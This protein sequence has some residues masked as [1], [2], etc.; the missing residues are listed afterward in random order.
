MKLLALLG[1]ENSSVATIAACVATDPVFT[2]RVLKRA[3]AADLA[4]YKPTCNILQALVT[5]GIERTRQ[6]TLTIATM[7]YLGKALK[8]EQ[9]RRCWSHT[10]ACALASSQ[11][12]EICG[13][14]PAEGYTAGL[15][16]DIGRLG[17]ITAYRNE[18]QAAMAQAREGDGDL[19]QA[20]RERFGVDH[21]EAGQWLAERWELSDILVKVARHHHEPPSGALDLLTAVQV[22]CPLAD[23]LGY[24]VSETPVTRTLDEIVAPLPLSARV[25]LKNG[26]DDLSARIAEQIAIFGCSN[27]QLPA[28]P[29]EVKLLED[30]EADFLRDFPCA[31]L[32]PPLVGPPRSKH[33]GIIAAVVV[34]LAAVLLVSLRS[35]LLRP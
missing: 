7:A 16:H 21:T 13:L 3:N 23:W 12:A 22:A 32:A 9:L 34:G 33:A 4:G 1:D 25:R 24:S 30:E 2:A 27:S 15:L 6:L 11:I 28:R 19:L 31:E 14:T 8:E 5:L 35:L 20:E 18:Y 29:I 10:V 26:L 17:L